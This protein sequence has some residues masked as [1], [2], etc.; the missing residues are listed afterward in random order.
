M[1]P[2]ASSPKL[3]KLGEVNLNQQLDIITMDGLNRTTLYQVV[4]RNF[5]HAMLPVRGHK[6]MHTLVRMAVL[7]CQGANLV[8]IGDSNHQVGLICV[9]MKTATEMG[10]SFPCELVQLRFTKHGWVKRDDVLALMIADARHTPIDQTM[11]LNSP[12]PTNHGTVVPTPKATITDIGDTKLPQKGGER[13]NDSELIYLKFEDQ[14]INITQRSLREQMKPTPSNKNKRMADQDFCHI[15]LLGVWLVA[16]DAKKLLDGSIRSAYLVPVSK[17]TPKLVAFY[18]SNDTYEHFSPQSVKFQTPDGLIVKMF[19]DTLRLRLKGKPVDFKNQPFR[20][21]PEL[22]GYISLHAIGEIEAS[23]INT[24]NLSDIKNGYIAGKRVTRTHRG[25]VQGEKPYYTLEPGWMKL[26]PAIEQLNN[27]ALTVGTYAPTRE[28]VM[29]A[30]AQSGQL[31]PDGKRLREILE[32][33]GKKFP[34]KE[35][36]RKAAHMARD[37]SIELEEIQYQNAVWAQ[38][39]TLGWL[40]LLA[41][42]NTATDKTGAGSPDG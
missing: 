20:F 19:R 32:K 13:N 11:R 14:S 29:S 38:M 10:Y 9:D 31:I 1:N 40:D 4:V 8:P 6:V 2:P 5:S 23:N 36:W 35:Q 15:E 42:I 37:I 26:A 27:N 17:S 18:R 16:S 7:R 39:D 33:T 21:L 28:A 30:L 24:F 25:H 12:R 41:K 34:S 22:H 3:G